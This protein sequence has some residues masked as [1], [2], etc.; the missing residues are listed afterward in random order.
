MK[1][2]LLQYWAL[3]FSTS[4]TGVRVNEPSAPGFNKTMA[5]IVTLIVAVGKYLSVA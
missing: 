3:L 1:A 2:R 5:G 4:V